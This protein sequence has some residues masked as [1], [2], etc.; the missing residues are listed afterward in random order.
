M[1]VESI[2]CNLCHGNYTHLELE[3]KDWLHGS[4]QTFRLV[5]C[6]ECGLTYINPR[7]TTNEIGRYYQGSY[8]SYQRADCQDWI[9]PEHHRLAAYL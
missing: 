7:P 5:R 6:K 9:R 3:A 4:Q 1:T 2:S 8:Y